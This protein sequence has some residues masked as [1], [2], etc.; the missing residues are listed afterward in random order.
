MG[1]AEGH[2]STM[3]PD[4]RL[5]VFA[6]YNVDGM[7]ELYPQINANFCFLSNAL[8]SYQQ[9]LKNKSHGIGCWKI[10]RNWARYVELLCIKDKRCM[11]CMN[12]RVA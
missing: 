3:Q 8:H 6:V 5:K 1:S 4:R 2:L 9:Y 7:D 12:E 11:P 10:K